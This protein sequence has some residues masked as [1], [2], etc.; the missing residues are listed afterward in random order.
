VG[1]RRWAVQKGSFAL[2]YT[3]SPQDFDGVLSFDSG[4][5][6]PVLAA[7]FGVLSRASP[8]AGRVWP[9]R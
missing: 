1:D 4:P 5:S 8:P 7:V 3:P 6:L 2:A 9:N